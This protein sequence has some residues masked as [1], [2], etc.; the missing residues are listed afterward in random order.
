MKKILLFLW[1]LSLVYAGYSQTYGFEQQECGIVQNSKYYI[2]NYQF[3]D[4]GEGY[5]LYH[6]GIIIEQNQGDIHGDFGLELRFIDDTTGFFISTVGDNE[7]LAVQKVT[8]NSIIS[9]GTFPNWDY[10]FFIVDKFTVYFVIYLDIP[11][12]PRWRIRRLSD[13]K[14]QKLLT[15]SI[16]AIDS[17]VYD[18][19]LGYPLCQNLKELDY[20]YLSL[21]DTITFK[22]KFSGDDTLANIDPLK[23]SGIVVYPNPAKE[24]IRIKNPGKVNLYSLSFLDDLGV[25]RKRVE[26]LRGEEDVYVGDLP[27]GM[28]FV[29]VESDGRRTVCKV[30]RM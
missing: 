16:Y 22:I 13:I 23:K 14:K 7:F 18:T 27:K 28:Y 8:N 24:F 12:N 6:N 4:H 20:R 5:R 30:V 26:K 9:L 15:N 21:T 17:T 3:S 1:L 25:V 29:V 2:E 11:N 10:D 19:I